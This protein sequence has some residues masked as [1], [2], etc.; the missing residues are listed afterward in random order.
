MQQQLVSQVRTA[1]LCINA[2]TADLTFN[3]RERLNMLNLNW[4]KSRAVSRPNIRWNHREPELVF[5]KTYVDFWSRRDRK[6]LIWKIFSE[7]D[8]VEINFLLWYCRGTLSGHQRTAGSVDQ[9]RQQTDLVQNQKRFLLF[10]SLKCLVPPYSIIYT[11]CNGHL[12]FLTPH[13]CH[14][15][16]IFMSA[17]QVFSMKDCTATQGA[18]CTCCWLLSNPECWRWW[19]SFWQQTTTFYHFF[20]FFVWMLELHCEKWWVHPEMLSPG[21]EEGLHWHGIESRKYCLML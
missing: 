5:M 15:L 6:L 1:A 18:R 19:R 20:V 12:F 10:L 9:T 2:A 14:R 17:A 4:R 16:M 21:E 13:K 8:C 3:N 7:N 11:R